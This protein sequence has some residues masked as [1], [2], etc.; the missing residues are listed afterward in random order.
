M[1]TRR[2][3]YTSRAVKEFTKYELM[4]LLHDSRAYNS[5]DKICGVLMHRNG[6]FLQVLEGEPDSIDNLLAR[7]LRD[8]RHENLKIIHDSSVD[9]LLF[10]NWAM[11]S[12]D[13]EAPELSLIPGL[14][15]DL[16]NPEVI[17]D[18]VIR[19]PDIASFLQG[20]GLGF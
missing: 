15:A 11:G 13:L 2:L 1:K 6:H 12:A 14:R 4:D 3:I 17:Q 16:S 10:S 19:L 20:K 7:L 18:L 8:P 5:I 9:T